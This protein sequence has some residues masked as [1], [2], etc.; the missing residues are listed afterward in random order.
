ME[1]RSIT[2][3]HEELILWKWTSYQ[4]Q[5]SNSVHL[6]ENSGDIPQRQ[7]KNN[8]NN[9]EIHIEAQKTKDSQSNPEQRQCCRRDDPT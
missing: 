9:L 7:K 5:S 1:D 3:V 2:H 6:Y 8:N 4:K